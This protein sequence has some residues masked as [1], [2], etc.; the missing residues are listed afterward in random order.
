MVEGPSQMFKSGSGGGE[1]DGDGDGEREEV[2][3]A[4]NDEGGDGDR[5]IV[6]DN[7]GAEDGEAVMGNGGVIVEQ[8]GFAGSGLD[9]G[10]CGGG[11]I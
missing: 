8:A 4:E 2:G 1:R 7:E 5:D 9:D 3:V 11:S 6:E 10:D